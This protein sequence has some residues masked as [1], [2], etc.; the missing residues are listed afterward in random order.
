MGVTT[1]QPPR[2]WIASYAPGVP[3]DLE[4]VTGSLVDIVEAAAREHPKAPAVEFFGH[5]QTYRELNDEIY[6][7]AG[8]LAALGVAHGTHVALVLPNCPQHV[9]AFYAVQRL[10]GVV[11][12]HNP[13]YTPGELE[14]LFRDHRAPIAIVWDKVAASI[15]EFADGVRPETLIAV[16]LIKAMPTIL[17]LAMLLPVPRLRANRAALHAPT[18]DTV[19]WQKLLRSHPL[20]D[21]H[22]KPTTDDLAVIQYTSGTTGTAKGVELTHRN[23]LSNAAQ[24]VA[25]GAEIPHG[26]G[27][28]VYGVLPMFHAYGLTLCATVAM[29][30]AA[31]LV[32]FP[33]FD[34]ALILAAMRKRPPTLFPLVPPIAGRLLTAA[35]QQGTT[36]AGTGIGI[37]GAMPLPPEIIP[38]FEASSGG[39]LVEGYGLSECAPILLIN[40]F[41][42]GRTAGAA[43]LPVPGTEARIVDPNEPTRDVE[44]GARGELVVRGP[45]VFRGYFG[46][47]EDTAASFA[48]GWFRTGDI[49][50]LDDRGFVRIVDR[51]KE[52]IIAGGFNVMPSEV[53]AELC[54]RA[55]IVGA[56]VVGLPDPHSGEEVAAG[57]V[58][59]PGATVDLDALR[60]SLRET[61]TPYK[62]P[63]RIVVVEELPV[64]QIGKVLRRQVRADLLAQ[65]GN[66]G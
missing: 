16:D 29:S 15:Q 13:L 22:P 41:G 25:W 62:V 6:R 7:V 38:A 42:E 58:L 10:G 65:L 47:P 54:A 55:E 61:L 21:D 11:I 57:I 3:D 56:A 26:E 24:C 17:Q 43:G 35:A 31:R 20:A 37:S 66:A 1:F 64:S 8:G 50:T 34:P 12:E 44:P 53:E 46:R 30:L 48:D 19:S 5:T 18:Y 49:A 4:P 14:H 27:C 52:L 9:V 51:I 32:L 36:L 59:A 33:K 45:Q 39:Y 2:P 63:H 60:D 40:P 28:V 23:L